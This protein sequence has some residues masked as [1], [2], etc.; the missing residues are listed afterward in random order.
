MSE[1]VILNLELAKKYVKFLEGME[2][3]RKTV[4]IG[5]IVA[6]FS[7]DDALKLVKAYIDGD[8]KIEKTPDEII[9]EIYKKPY[10]DGIY[11]S[12]YLRCK[13]R[14]IRKILNVLEKKI[15]G[16]NDSE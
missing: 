7:D 9:M 11:N 6:R 10:L 13:Q 2:G 5:N 8:Y 14:D 15:K 16:I 3:Q 1:K 12:N 4:I